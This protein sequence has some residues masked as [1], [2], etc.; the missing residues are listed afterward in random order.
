MISEKPRKEV[1]TGEPKRLP[2]SHSFAFTLVEL[3]IV[4]LLMGIVYGIAFDTFLPKSPEE[5]MKEGLTLKTVD[6]LFR[7]S[8]LYGTSE[9]TLYCTESGDCYLTSGG[10]VTERVSVQNPGIA[11]RLN[12]DETLQRIDYPHI[13]LGRDEF[14]PMFLVRCREDGLFEPQ[15]IRVGERWLYIHPYL[16]PRFFD[17]VTTLVGSMRQSD[18]LPDRA[19]YA[20]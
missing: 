4:L 7:Q 6:T 11:Y 9:M 5:N 20:Q 19:G 3:L 8:P 2:A 12:P 16:P 15:I 13:R 10:K 1:D 18:Y 17:D 14:R